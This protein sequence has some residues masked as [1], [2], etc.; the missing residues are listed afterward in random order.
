GEMVFGEE[1]DELQHAVVRLLRAR[2][3]TLATAE[4]G[5]AGRLAHWLSEL[6]ESAGVYRG[7]LVA[8]AGS[9]DELIQ[10]ASQLASGGAEG[11]RRQF[12]ADYGLAISPIAA[13]TAD[14]RQPQEYF[15]ALADTEGVTVHGATNAG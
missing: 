7:G 13:S 9:G 14:D 8:A 4:C 2:K 11:C 3:Q 1:D 12:T 15:F 10:N 5:T 6:G